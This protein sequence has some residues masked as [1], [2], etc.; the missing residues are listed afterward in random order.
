MRFFRPFSHR[1]FAG[2]ALLGVFV[3]AAQ[4][5]NRALAQFSSAPENSSN[6]ILKLPA[7]PSKKSGAVSQPF[8]AQSPIPQK[9]KGKSAPVVIAVSTSE[10]IPIPK[11]PLRFPG[12]KI[13]RVGLSTK[14]G[15]IAVYLPG[16]ATLFD[17]NQP[18]LTLS[19]SRG[20]QLQFLFGAPRSFKR[21]AKVFRGPISVA[22][23]SGNFAGW[24]RIY[25]AVAGEPARVSSN[26][27]SARYA[28]PYRGD[29]EV[30]PQKMGEPVQR[31]GALSLV[32]VLPLEAYLKGVVPW[33]MSPDAPLEA[34]K[35][36][37]I[38]ARTK[39]LDFVRGKRFSKGNFDICDYDACQ[40]YPGTENEK[41]ATSAAVEATKGLA[42]YQNG[43]P[44]DA[45]YSTNSG[46]VTASARDVWKG[47][48]P[49]SYLQSVPDFPADSPLAKLWQDGM[50]EA[51]WAQFCARDWPSYARPDGIA[52]TKYEARK[53][54]WNQE[55]SVP[56]AS[57]AFVAD[58]IARVT[59]IQILERA[60]SGRI[61]RLRVSGFAPSKTPTQ[62]E[63]TPPQQ[64]KIQ[65]LRIQELETPKSVDLEG[66]GKIRAMFSKRLG[67]T[68]A[69]PSSLFTI[70][71]LT[72]ASGQIIGWNL[73]G[74]GWGH[75]VGMC[76]RG[77][78][79]HAR[80]GWDARKILNFYYRG[81]EIR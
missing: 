17:L 42:I 13:V 26:N 28:R 43:R 30:F 27:Q 77:A 54:R 40:G 64:L 38:C 19:P 7:P 70:S 55:I 76:Q 66:D 74:A 73:Q 57:K 47:T 20:A 41:L 36:Q 22:T 32:N 21:G 62:I 11:L 18:G 68:T 23:P 65:E 24:Q 80:E 48:T 12:Q 44:I 5:Q 1:F 79:N 31:K 72:D 16:G 45:V 2:A 46:G 4:I 9:M 75:G 69:L 37:A 49:I 53:Y 6:P 33:E 51:E 56:E 52:P 78:Q 3:V 34:L 67:S 58:G 29:L 25:I 39:T 61:R 8:K 81:V 59:N 14:G 15:A 71:P 60:A 50:T 35:A 10:P 63:I